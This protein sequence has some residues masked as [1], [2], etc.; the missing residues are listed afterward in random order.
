MTDEIE[1]KTGIETNT[2][3]GWS[4]PEGTKRFILAIIALLTLAYCVIAEIPIPEFLIT[5]VSMMIAFFFGGHLPIG[6]KK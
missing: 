3:T 5:T 2:N 4:L 6:T 1:A